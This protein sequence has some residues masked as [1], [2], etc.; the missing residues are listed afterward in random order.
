[1]IGHLRRGRWLTPALAISNRIEVHVVLW[2]VD[3]IH[4]GRL[5]T[6]KALHV[7]IS[8]LAL[9]T[10]LPSKNRTGV[11]N[12]FVTCLSWSCAENRAQI[13]RRCALY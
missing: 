12:F 11:R 10:H 9:A 5:T 8:V 1:M 4:Q 13:S 3:E 7:A 2:V 6:A